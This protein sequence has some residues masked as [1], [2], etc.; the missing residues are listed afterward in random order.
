MF[1][2]GPFHKSVSFKTSLYY[3]VLIWASD[4]KAG[5]SYKNGMDENDISG[6]YF[7]RIVM[8]LRRLEERGLGKLEAIC[9]LNGNKNMPL[10]AF[11]TKDTNYNGEMLITAGH[12]VYNIWGPTQAL[13][14]LAESGEP[15]LVIVPVVD[16]RNYHKADQLRLKVENDDV[17]GPTE[18]YYAL[19]GHKDIAP[20]KGNDW[21]DYNYAGKS[22]EHIEKLKEMIKVS[23]FYADLYNGKQNGFRFFE[24][25]VQNSTEEI[26]HEA[27]IKAIENGGQIIY[28]GGLNFR[29]G[30]P[31]N[32]KGFNSIKPHTNTSISFAGRHGIPNLAVEI[33]ALYY[34]NSEMRLME[35]DQ[36]A[37]TTIEMILNSVRALR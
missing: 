31:C 4:L 25:P 36:V 3:Y 30:E 11:R 21:D 2:M 8:P 17:L 32:H 1:S 34:K 23:G 13:M 37:G 5:Q 33:P 6:V 27:M 35:L 7:Q 18:M 19:Y 29:Y 14:Q 24:V 26:V 9:H 16:V 12:N 22:P 10:V 20:L 28:D 15:G